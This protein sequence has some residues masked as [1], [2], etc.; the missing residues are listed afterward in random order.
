M[1]WLFLGKGPQLRVRGLP[2]GSS[3]CFVVSLL[4]DFHH[5]TKP[6]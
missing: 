1:V 6:P 2:A 4:C 3:L 5:V